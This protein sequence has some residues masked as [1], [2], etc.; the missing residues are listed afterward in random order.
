[1]KI[2]KVIWASSIEYSDFWNINSYLHKKFL[3]IDCVLLL[4]GDKAECN[5]SEE[6]GKVVELEF[7]EDLDK[8]PQLVFNKWHY[9][10]NEPDTVWMI[11]DI[12]QLP[13]QREHF[14]ENIANV[15]QDHYM[16]L[17]EDAGSHL[18]LNFLVGHY[19]VAKGSTLS[20]CLELEKSLEHHVNKIIKEAKES[21]RPVWAYEEIYTT[22]LIKKNCDGKFTGTSRVND[23]KICRSN[24]CLFN[25]NINNYYVDMHCPRPFNQHKEKIMDVLKHFW[26]NI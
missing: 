6:F 10:K 13:L 16:H 15:P 9:T 3:G 11:G 17:A 7:V 1:M 12:D 20:K 22:D 21:G 14:V 2:D 18:G 5:V 19:H 24:D 23:R 8:I 4:Y 25:R 26:G